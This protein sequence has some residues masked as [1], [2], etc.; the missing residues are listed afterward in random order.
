MRGE[1][2]CIDIADPAFREKADSLHKELKDVL[3]KF[4]KENIGKIDDDTLFAMRMEATGRIFIGAM[5][6]PDI[7]TGC[8]EAIR[9]IKFLKKCMYVANIETYESERP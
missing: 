2:F 8:R 5:G 3:S 9:S 6:T 4:T 1:S 7:K